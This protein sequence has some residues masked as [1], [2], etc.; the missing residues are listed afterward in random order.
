ML[1][2]TVAVIGV[3]LIGGSLARDLASQGVRVLGHDEDAA[4]VERARGEGILAGVLDE[5]FAGLAAAEIV[6][7]ATPV[8]RAPATLVR[9]AP[10]LGP[11]AVVTDVGSTKASIVAEA[12]RLGLAA[13][14]IGS[15]PVAGDHRAGWEASRFGL[16]RGAL[17]HLCPPAGGSEDARRVVEAMWASAGARCVVTDA[18]AHDELMAWVSALPQVVA[19]AVA[20]ALAAS[21][22]RPADLGPGGRDVTRL[23]ASSPAMWVPICLENSEA[24]LAAVRAAQ[25]RLAEFESAL[26]SRD[27]A[28]LTRFFESGRAWR[29]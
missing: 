14:F 12:E 27:A 3:G 13:R 29:V 16:F 8:D 28:A 4:R 9:I 15:H 26:A 10:H 23:A 19:S 21:G 2:R 6:V 5:G 18:R 1:D 24:V 20:G 17:V 22:T 25:G 7:I 11:K